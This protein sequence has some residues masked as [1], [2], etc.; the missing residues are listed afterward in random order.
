MKPID[1]GKTFLVEESRRI[2]FRVVNRQARAKLLEALLK[3]EM[4]SLGFDL[5]L[6]TSKTGYGGLR[7]WFACPLCGKRKLV[8]HVHPLSQVVGCRRCLGLE[9]RSQRFKGMPESGK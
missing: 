9:Y 1:S 7:Y 3:A 6:S 2:D 5:P 4:R 8:L